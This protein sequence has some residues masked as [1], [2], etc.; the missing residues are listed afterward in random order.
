V[1]ACLSWAGVAGV[2]WMEG[3][4]GNKE[5]ARREGAEMERVSVSKCE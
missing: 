4:G 3:G 2:R 5:R 1:G